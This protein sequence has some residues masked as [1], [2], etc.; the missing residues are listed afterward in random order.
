MQGHIRH[1]TEEQMIA[2][3]ED[4]DRHLQARNGSEIMYV[5]SAPPRMRVSTTRSSTL[6]ADADTETLHCTFCNKSSHTSAKCKNK[7]PY[8]FPKC[9]AQV[10]HLQSSPEKG[11][12]NSNPK[13]EGGNAK[14]N[15]GG[16]E[17]EETGLLLILSVNKTGSHKWEKPCTLEKQK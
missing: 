9:K 6:E 4:E 10:H 1:L 5:V 14:Q 16:K 13:R 17:Q 12:R 3:I 15:N 7:P 8:Y 2:Y 11:K